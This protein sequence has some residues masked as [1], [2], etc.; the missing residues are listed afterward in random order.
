M[1]REGVGS[2]VIGI[3]VLATGSAFVVTSMADFYLLVKVILLAFD[4]L[5]NSLKEVMNGYF[6]SRFTKRTKTLGLVS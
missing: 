6:N 1:A 3:L 5:D 4:Y 2:V